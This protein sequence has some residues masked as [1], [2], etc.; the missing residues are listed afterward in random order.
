MRQ[1]TPSVANV[2]PNPTSTI[3]TIPEAPPA[4]VQGPNLKPKA[5][6]PSPTTVLNTSNNNNNSSTNPSNESPNNSMN[7]TR[8]RLASSSDGKSPRKDSDAQL[9]QQHSLESNDGSAAQTTASSNVP[10]NFIQKTLNQHALH[11]ISKGRLRHLGYMA[12]NI[13]DFDLLNW[14]RTHR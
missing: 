4:P 5:N 12:A 10:I 13:T 11:A 9:S 1:R 7:D 14:L 6:W 3:T 8:K 2:V